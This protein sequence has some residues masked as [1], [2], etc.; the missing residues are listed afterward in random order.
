MTKIEK[1]LLVVSNYNNDLSWIPNYTNNY[2]IYDKNSS[3]VR[4]PDN[5]DRSKVIKSIN[6]GYNFYDYFTF[7]IDNYNKLPDTIMFV[8]G[9]VFPRHVT[10]E[11][12]EK[13]MNN[14]NFTPIEEQE[15][16]TPKLPISFFSPDGGYNE[17]NNSWY[18]KHLETKYFH[19]YNDFLKF[20]YKKPLIPRYIRFA[21]G[22]NYI[23]KKEQILSVP[24]IVYENLRFIISHCPLA[25][26]T[27]IIER[28]A[29][30]LW[31]SNFEFNHKILSPLSLTSIK[32]TKKP[33][34]IYAKL[35]E[36]I[37]NLLS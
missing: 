36:L 32:Q 19:N 7:I 10:K 21:P 31:N 27:H 16:H 30:T 1:N 8:K 4:I 22:G 2:V 24:K 37:R 3:G 33:H 11:H 18:L 26:E 13:I 20:V 6:V 25:G 28:F 35:R 29:Y 9:N 5:I 12:F 14:E 34:F 23:L 15:M 17:I